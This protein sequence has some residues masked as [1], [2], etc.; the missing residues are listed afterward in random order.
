MNMRLFLLELYTPAVFRQ[1]QLRL[2]MQGTAE[3]WGM[4]PPPNK[5]CSWRHL[6][7]QYADFT[8]QLVAEAV[9]DA[10]LEDRLFKAA[11]NM[12][13]DLRRR[14]KVRRQDEVG[15]ALRLIY[16]G[17]GIDLM[18]TGMD[19]IVRRCYFQRFYT[20][21]ACRLMAAMDKGLVAGV[22]GGCRL[23]FQYRLTEGNACCKA[24]LWPPGQ[25][26]E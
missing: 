5:P 24:R 4:T 15:R 7:Q 10:Y 6:L 16:R 2:L 13:S 26:D 25:T 8:A 23:E 1:R 3:A 19:I 20:P 9:P 14:L 22:S 21:Q 18:V 12:G 17:L 11:Y